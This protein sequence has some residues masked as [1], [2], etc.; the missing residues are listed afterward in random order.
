MF[1]FEKFN[2]NTGDCPYEIIVFDVVAFHCPLECLWL[3]NRSHT[4]Y[5][6]GQ[7]DSFEKETIAVCPCLAAQH[8]QLGLEDPTNLDIHNYWIPFFLYSCW[9]FMPLIGSGMCLFVIVRFDFHFAPIKR[10]KEIITIQWPNICSIPFNV[11]HNRLRF[12]FFFFFFTSLL[13]IALHISN[14]K[15]NGVVEVCIWPTTTRYLSFNF[16]I[17]IGPYSAAHCILCNDFVVSVYLFVHCVEFHW[18]RCFITTTTAAAAIV[19]IKAMT[20]ES[21]ILEIVCVSTNVV[22]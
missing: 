12:F 14:W 8:I 11:L 18:R 3:R 21:E 16:N 7:R 1:A 13:S 20:T 17:S 10:A 15:I 2:N 9:T 19:A 5:A 4:L 6:E 22:Q